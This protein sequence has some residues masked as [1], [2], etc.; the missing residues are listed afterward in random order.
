MKSFLL[1]AARRIYHRLPMSQVMKWRLRERLRPLLIFLQGS[2]GLLGLAKAFESVVVSR[3]SV[4]AG[5]RSIEREGALA[6]MLLKI[7]V[8]SQTYGAARSWMALPFL[9]T[10]GAQSVALNF[11]RAIRSLRPNESV[12]LLVTDRHLGEADMAIPDGVLILIFDD[13]LPADR[14]Y[15]TKQALLMDLVVATR[16]SLF[17]NVNSEVAWHLILEQGQKL[18]S[19]TRLFASIFAFQYLPQTRQKVGYAASFLERGLPHLTGLLTDNRRFVAD[20]ITEYGL[21]PAEAAK[22]HVVYQPCRLDGGSWRAAPR[23]EAMVDRRLKVLWAG[24]L[25][26][27]KRV[28]LF[29]QVVRAC[30]FADFF[31]FGKVV[32][33]D[34]AALPEL[35][36]LHYSGPFSSPLEWLGQGPYDAFLFT[37]RWE[38]MPNTL[39]EAGSLG[40]AVVAPTVGGVGELIRKDTGYPLPE[41]PTAD[42]YLQMLRA[43]QADPAEASRRADALRDLVESRHSWG[44]FVAA[45]ASIDDYFP[46]EPLPAVRPADA[47][48]ASVGDPLVS[49]V[50][51]CFN[52]GQYLLQSVLSA[53]Q[54]CRDWPL[55]IIVVDDGSTDGRMARWLDEAKALAPDVVRIHRQT[56]AGLSAARNAGVSMSRGE[57][58]QFLDAD[59]LLAPCKIDVQV[60]QL[61]LQ[62]NADVSVCNFLLSDAT[63]SYFSKPEEAIARFDLSVEDFLYRWERGFA[64][65]IHCGLFRR[66]VLS[67]D[68]PFDT[69]ARA[70]E[71]WIFWSE[72]ALGGARFAYVHGHWAIYR[73]HEA[74]MRRSYMNMGRAWLRAGLHLDAK[75]RA[76]H[77][78]F[79]ESVM[80]WFE[81]CYRA[82]DEYRREVALLQEQ[83]TRKSLTA[84][85]NVSERPESGAPADAGEILER[86]DFLS[87][88][89]TPFL[90]VVVPIY[91]H[92]G[93]LR[94][95]LLSLAEQ[96][97]VTFEII[98]I[99]DASTDPRV[100]QLLEQLRGR[101][102]G[103]SVQILE[104]NVGISAVQNRAVQVA[105]G[106]YIAFLDCDDALEPRALQTVAQ[107]LATDPAIDYL[108]TARTDV[109]ESGSAVRTAVYGGYENIT[110]SSQ[111]RIRD[112]LL[113]G[114]VASHLKVIRRSVYEEVGGSDDRYSG[115]QDWELALKI[116]ERHRLHYLNEPLYRHRVHRH[117]V[118]RS[119]GMAQMRKTNQVRR[120]FTKLRYPRQQAAQNIGSPIVFAQTDFPIALD[121]FK[122]VWEQGRICCV[123]MAGP[124]HLSSVNFLR[125]FNSYVDQIRWEDPAVPIALYGYLHADLELVDPRGQLGRAHIAR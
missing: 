103:L 14:S 65:P 93:Y 101:L 46:R 52:Q 64:I 58:V 82:S 89:A 42:H 60:A 91:G 115:V 95:C 102:P 79:F 17:H 5:G 88:S 8:H 110:F 121:A 55:E 100:P 13:F 67:H 20:A 18:R 120:H 81:Q 84:I 21:P 48:C 114:M 99:D 116:A 10:G 124:L 69:A 96:G 107:V 53:L 70:K 61:R 15:V 87:A 54:A 24:R 111:E 74:S 7:E 106:T 66:D 76:E 72:L 71:D 68:G 49:V 59:D 23:P 47:G 51:P 80:S 123:D 77:P 39:I 19:F 108:F 25:D 125:E 11:C 94:E 36:N 38:G 44:A 6:S 117:S 16:P 75:V 2:E 37:S 9:S 118:T 63:V 109:D 112:D 3:P 43:I 92:Y 122:R 90:T 97:D 4:S 12:V 34:G 104:H 31:V 1:T 35:P 62:A 78:M 32:L 83:R 27:E 45:F 85:V 105:Q 98:C 113:D 33:E 57:Y 119:D 30:D 56:N 40:L 73:Q 41:A 29:L 50:V 28:D 22:L 26:A 86:L